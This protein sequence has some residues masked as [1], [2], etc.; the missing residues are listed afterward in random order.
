MVLN[1]MAAVGSSIM[2]V[3]PNGLARTP[4]MGWMSWEIFRCQTDCVNYPNSCV[5]DVL[6]TQMADHLAEDGYLAAGYTTVSIDDCWEDLNGRKNGTLVPDP[7]RF[8]NG[9]EA[10][11]N[12]MHSKG[13][14]F[15]IVTWIRYKYCGL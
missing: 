5:N 6:Y 10:L 2:S 8:P 7:K 12:L 3:G 9:M 15:G 11:G 14:N 4:P 13:V 1:F